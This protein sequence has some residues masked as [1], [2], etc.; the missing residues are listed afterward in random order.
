MTLLRR[1]EQGSSPTPTPASH[2]PPAGPCCYLIDFFSGGNSREAV[3]LILLLATLV[4]YNWL[5]SGGRSREA[6]FLLLMLAT[7]ILLALYD[8]VNE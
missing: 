2:T 4:L 3:P 8:D 1:K 6:V 5:F 7:L